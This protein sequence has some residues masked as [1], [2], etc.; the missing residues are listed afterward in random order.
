MEKQTSAGHTVIDLRTGRSADRR[1]RELARP[2]ADPGWIAG[3]LNREGIPSSSDRPWSP[4]DV[5]AVLSHRT[6]A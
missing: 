5:L 6:P 4:E 3:I 2:G 1:I